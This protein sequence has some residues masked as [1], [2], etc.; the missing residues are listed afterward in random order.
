MWQPAQRSAKISAPSLDLGGS[1]SGAEMPSE[2]QA[3]S[4]AAAAATAGREQSRRRRGHERRHSIREIP[5]L[6]ALPARL[7]TAVIAAAALAAA[8]AAS[9]CG[10]AEVRP[11]RR[12]IARVTIAMHDYYFRPQAARAEPGSC[13]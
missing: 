6:D 11:E 9:G 3:T 13:G 7:A 1:L 2:P 5:R 8:G 4:A 12:A 10:G